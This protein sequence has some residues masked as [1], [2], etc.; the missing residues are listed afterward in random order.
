MLFSIIIS[1]YNRSYLLGKAI[2]S[3]LDQSNQDFEIIVSD[4]AS[5]DDT[6]QIVREFN[7]SRIAYLYN[8][9]N[10]G[11]SAARNT[12]IKLAKGEYII[13]MDDDTILKND[14]LETLKRAAGNNEVNVLCPRILEPVTN[15]PFVGI[16]SNKKEKYL[17]Y[18]DFNYFIGL[19]HAI[20]K[21]I[22][23][24]IGS[25]DERFGV[26]SK[27]RAAEES[28]YFFRLKQSREAVLYC[29]ELVVY[30]PCEKDTSDSKAFNYAYGISAMLT[31]NLISDLSHLHYYLLIILNR[32]SVSLLRSLQC[33]FFPKS[34]YYKNK[35]Y[36]YKSFFQGSIKGVVDYL[37]FR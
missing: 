9:V 18:F 21:E 26:G 15:E 30:H 31:K 3:I 8:K 7:D 28:D 11:L 29:P 17:G 5:I 27:Y 32:V 12:A 16:F 2:R 23:L 14:F 1:T 33:I 24:K 13:F 6:G 4:D 34:I 36:K 37:R 10:S 19:A 25:F 20:R 22:V 35:I